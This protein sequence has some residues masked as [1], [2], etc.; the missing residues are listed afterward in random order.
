MSTFFFILGSFMQLVTITYLKRLAYLPQKVLIIGMLMEHGIGRSLA[1]QRFFQFA[2]IIARK[3]ILNHAYL[4]SQSYLFI[5][6]MNQNF[7]TLQKA[8]GSGEL[9]MLGFDG[10]KPYCVVGVIS[11]MYDFIFFMMFSIIS[12]LKQN[13]LFMNCNR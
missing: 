2:F 7:F 11:G 1:I 8:P 6:Y 4:V 9:V 13:S 3:S 10:M 5:L 12:N